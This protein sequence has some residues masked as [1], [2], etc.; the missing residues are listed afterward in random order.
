M[1]W[2]CRRRLVCCR[3]RRI[4]F[5]FGWGWRGGWG[6]GGREGLGDGGRGGVGGGAGGVCLVGG[7]P[8][9]CLLARL[10]PGAA[11]GR[12]LGEAES[13][14]FEVAVERRAA[15]VRSFVVSAPRV[16]VV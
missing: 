12:W 13:F 2:R 14:L 11:G 16:I 10:M 5:C 4:R 1:A 3:G 15:A 7:W 9:L 8:L 6:W